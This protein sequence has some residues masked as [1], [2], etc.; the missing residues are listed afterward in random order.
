VDASGNPVECTEACTFDHTVSVTNPGLEVM[1]LK[2]KLKRATGNVKVPTDAAYSFDI[3]TVVSVIGCENECKE[4]EPNYDGHSVVKN[5]RD[6]KTVSF[7]KEE[8]FS[9]Y[10]SLFSLDYV[11][12]SKYRVSFTI[13]DSDDSA[14][15]LTSGIDGY[16]GD[17][18]AV[19]AKVNF[20]NIREDFTKWSMGWKIT[21]NVIT[22]LAMFS[23]FTC[24]DGLFAGFFVQMRN[25]PWKL[26]SDMQCWIAVLL[27]GLF[28][29]N[30]PLFP[31]QVYSGSESTNNGLSGFYI[32]TLSGFLATLLCFM[33]CTSEDIASSGMSQFLERKTASYY[34]PKAILCG[35]LWIL[36]VVFYAIARLNNTGDPAYD[37][38]ASNNTFLAF[39]IILGVFLAIWAAW[40]VVHMVKSVSKVCGASVPYAFLFFITATA[41]LLAIVGASIGALYPLPTH[42][43]DF[44]FFYG[45]FNLYVWMLAFSY[46]PATDEGVEAIE[47]GGNNELYDNLVDS[48]G[49]A[50][51]GRGMI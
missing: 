5:L 11:E 33:L 3:D 42:A 37:S 1:Y 14:A 44:L 17:V 22:L 2:L 32:V 45:C 13:T 25:V 6:F 48:E 7:D 51:N 40:F 38:L 49:N 35:A 15:V 28:F 29:F 12:Y 4:G 26:W 41:A 19:S 36:T 30:D 16:T 10:F 24:Y 9:T 47:L 43:F 31:V 23:P 20:S 18:D 46:A 34:V 39:E 21:F 8:E 27:V 50:G